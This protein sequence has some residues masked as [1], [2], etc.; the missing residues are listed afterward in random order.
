MTRNNGMENRVIIMS[1]M[2]NMQKCNENGQNSAYLFLFHTC[3]LRSMRWKMKRE[4]STR[5]AELTLPH[6]GKEKREERE[7]RIGEERVRRV[8]TRRE[9]SR[10]E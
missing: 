9:R 2:R 6:L 10:E 1:R 4:M 5:G 3:T 7:E 8:E